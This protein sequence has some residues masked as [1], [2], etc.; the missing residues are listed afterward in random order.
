[1]ETNVERERHAVCSH[2]AIQI[3]DRRLRGAV[4]HRDAVFESKE[5]R[6]LVEAEG[7]DNDQIKIEKMRQ[8]EINISEDYARDEIDE[9]AKGVLIGNAYR[10]M[11]PSERGEYFSTK[12]LST[13]ERNK[14]ALVRTPDLF[15][16]AKYLSEK[17]DKAF[18]GKCRKAM[19]DT[20]G[21]VD[22]PEIPASEIKKSEKTAL[23]TKSK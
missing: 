23:D 3:R 7:K 16:I 15:K 17:T 6:F 5:G 10:L 12:C 18:A 20:V 22:F 14:T 21:V 4:L 13:A 1:M 2:R 8:L 9:M 11:E 19:L